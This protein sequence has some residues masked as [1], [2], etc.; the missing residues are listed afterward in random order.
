MSGAEHLD[1]RA[2][3]HGHVLEHVS[4]IDRGWFEAHPE[5]STYTRRPVEH[6]G[7]CPLCAGEGRGCVPAV[8]LRAVRVVQLSPGVR[9]RHLLGPPLDGCDHEVPTWEPPS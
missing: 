3:L 7:C 9:I 2:D 6:E 4:D 8:N 1:L 5:A